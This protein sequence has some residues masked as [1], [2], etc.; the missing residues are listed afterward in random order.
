MRSMQDFH[1]SR[2]LPNLLMTYRGRAA[3]V[4]AE[5]F[6][7]LQFRLD[8]V[9]KVKD[10]SRS[11][12]SVAVREDGRLIRPEMSAKALKMLQVPS[13]R[14]TATTNPVLV[15]REWVHFVRK[16]PDRDD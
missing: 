3:R 12:L 7:S 5:D 8:R 16:A 2:F 9:P 14:L 4:A 11:G 6:G 13:A 1:S 15:A 10:H